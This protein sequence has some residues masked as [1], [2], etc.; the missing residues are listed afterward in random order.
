ME[1]H[2]SLIDY[3]GEIDYTVISKILVELK[4]HT[5]ILKSPVGV[6]KR[7]LSVT[8]E[9]LCN[10]SMYTKKTESAN[11]QFKDYPPYYQFSANSDSFRIVVRS[12]IRAVETKALSMQIERINGFSKQEQKELYKKII[13][14]GI[15]SKQGG[16]GLGLLI[17]ARSTDKKINYTF[18]QINHDWYYFSIIVEITK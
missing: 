7:L 10:I 14:N 12:A 13:S 17:I 11:N 6:Y 9:T 5:D 1:S 16:A 4:S 15:F 8:D 2:K 3:S 18:E